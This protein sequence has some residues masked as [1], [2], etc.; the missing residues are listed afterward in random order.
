MDLE[1]MPKFLDAVMK[2]VRFGPMSR[3]AIISAFLMAN[4]FGHA[5]QPNAPLPVLQSDPLPPGAERRLGTT[6]LRLSGPVGYFMFSPDDATLMVGSGGVNVHFWETKTW[7]ETWRTAALAFS[8]SPDGKHIAK[9][10]SERTIEIWDVANKALVHARDLARFGRSIRIFDIEFNARGDALWVGIA[11]QGAWQ[12]NWSK[13]EIVH[14]IQA[15]NVVESSLVQSRDRK[16]LAL[17][18][19]PSQ[20]TVYDGD[21]GR[22][23]H[24]TRLPHAKF[25]GAWHALNHD[26]KILATFNQKTGLAFS[27]LIS[28]RSLSPLPSEAIQKEQPSDGPGDQPASALGHE[29]HYL[30]D[31]KGEYC[32]LAGRKMAIAIDLAKKKVIAKLPLLDI[33]VTALAI[34][35]NNKTLALGYMDGAVEIL[36]LVTLKP[37][38][39][40][41]HP[42][43]PAL[44]VVFAQHGQSVATYHESGS[45][46]RLWNLR[47]STIVKTFNTDTSTESRNKIALRFLPGDGG[48]SFGTQVRWNLATGLR[49]RLPETSDRLLAAS[50]DGNRWLLSK[51]DGQRVFEEV[52]LYDATAQRVVGKLPLD[53][54]ANANRTGNSI[55]AT[56]SADGNWVGLHT[57]P[58]TNID[59]NTGETQ[60]SEDTIAVWYVRQA[61]PSCNFSLSF[62]STAAAI[63]LAPDGRFLSV[64]SDPKHQGLAAPYLNDA[65]AGQGFL[66][67]SKGPLPDQMWH[68]PTGFLLWKMAPA[69]AP[70][71]AGNRI[72]I[73]ALDFDELAA[74]GMIEPSV[75]SPDAQFLAGP[76]GEGLEVREALSGQVLLTFKGQEGRI[77]D[78]AFSPDGRLLASATSD[79]TVILWSVPPFATAKPGTWDRRHF[80]RLWQDLRGDA[81]NAYQAMANLCA[82]GNEAALLLQDRIQLETDDQ[83]RLM[84]QT[85]ADLA[86]PKFSAREQAM[87]R[88]EK[89]GFRVK[90]YLAEAIAQ[91]ADLEQKRRLKTLLTRIKDAGIDPEE[92]RLNR[93]VI[94]LERIAT[95]V[96][97]IILQGLA[98]GHSLDLTAQAARSALAR[99]H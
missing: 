7:R 11:S 66:M 35:N 43:G 40:D 64:H 78:L 33:P 21:T 59:P 3:L 26:G 61:A 70:Q 23:L 5:A 18:Q 95:P 90:P 34:S 45:A 1:T 14:R 73:A 93:S 83:R 55:R 96:A 63:A 30:F 86:A 28:G 82:G 27:E 94:V 42:R 24:E 69:K 80:E 56:F 41:P 68:V 36:E 31:A 16:R 32:L 53:V 60:D 47:D 15:P 65:P 98:R 39:D 92:L 48:L 4:A 77:G 76:S 88:L 22:L 87:V 89:G 74:P 75:F 49:S 37:L 9:L 25:I 13:D 84:Q 79:S 72:N 8:C 44:A 50:T 67:A 71:V 29:V 2:W 6:R 10:T 12:Y 99:L 19:N 85:L 58:V 81:K 54:S 52:F 57:S 62:D 17:R 91:S 20:I 38:V 97:Q 51:E 46:V